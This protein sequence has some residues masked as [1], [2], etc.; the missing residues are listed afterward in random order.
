[1]CSLLHTVSLSFP[2]FGETCFAESLNLKTNLCRRWKDILPSPPL[3]TTL[4]TMWLQLAVDSCETRAADKSQRLTAAK[5]K[6]K[7]GAFQLQPLQSRLKELWPWCQVDLAEQWWKKIVC[8]APCRRTASSRS[9]RSDVFAC[10]DVLAFICDFFYLAVI[11]IQLLK[12]EFHNQ[13]HFILYY[14]TEPGHKEMFVFPLVAWQSSCLMLYYLQISQICWRYIKVICQTR[15]KI[16]FF[17]EKKE[18]HNRFIL[19]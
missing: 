1:M 3:F 18:S 16:Y 17:I 11:Q 6:K 8:W 7:V 10:S 2:H 5:K 19:F 4:L 12:V 9:S 13:L 14:K 15:C